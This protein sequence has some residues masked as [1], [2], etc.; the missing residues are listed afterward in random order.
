MNGI[1]PGKNSW[2]SSDGTILTNKHCKDGGWEC[3][4]F[5]LVILTERLWW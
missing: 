5:E 4:M 2:R 3:C 1:I